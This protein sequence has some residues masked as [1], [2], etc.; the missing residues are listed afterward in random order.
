MPWKAMRRQRGAYRARGFVVGVDAHSA[1]ADYHVGVFVEKFAYRVAYQFE[2]V[3]AETLPDERASAEAFKLFEQFRTEGVFHA[4]VD[5]FLACGDE[6]DFERAEGK[7]RKGLAAADDGDGALDAVVL[8]HERTDAEACDYLPFEHGAVRRE[9]GEHPVRV[10]IDAVDRFREVAEHPRRFG[11]EV[12][13]PFGGRCD[14]EVLSAEHF[15]ELHRR[16]VFVHVA[17]RELH[18]GE[19][20]A[21]HAEHAI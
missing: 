15:A 9:R 21:S 2:R 12:A 20:F 8:Q 3:G 17:G 14:A 6:A 13:A 4:F 18:D 5:D 16:V 10:L 7:Y 1:C 19:V 11:Y